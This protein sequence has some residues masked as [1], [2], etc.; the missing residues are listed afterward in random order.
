[1]ASP[2]PAR[3]RTR[4]PGALLAR[5]PSLA[6]SVM[7]SIMKT[8]ET[9]TIHSIEYSS[10]APTRELVRMLPGPIT[11]QAVIRPGPSRMYHGRERD[12]FCS[13]SLMLCLSPRES[14]LLTD[15]FLHSAGW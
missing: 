12:A 10:F 7:Y 11:T 9:R 2:L 15:P 6:P 13:A 8:T 1:M 4:S 3:S 14:F 5:T